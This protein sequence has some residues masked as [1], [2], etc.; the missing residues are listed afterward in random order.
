M[1][2]QERTL[3]T[4]HHNY[5]TNDQWYKEFTTRSDVTNTIGVTRQHKVLLERVAQEKNSDSFEKIKEEKQKTVRVDTKEIYFA[6][7]LLQ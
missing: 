3:Y 4:L 5:V 7:V 6:Y 1:Y 2:E